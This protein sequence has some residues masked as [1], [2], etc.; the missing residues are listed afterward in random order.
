MICD[1]EREHRK[2][3]KD[4]DR[5]LLTLMMLSAV[6]MADAYLQRKMM[7]YQARSLKVRG[8]GGPARGYV[9]DV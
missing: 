2:T 5:L 7:R 1:D 3:L 8:G 4:N 9:G 6:P